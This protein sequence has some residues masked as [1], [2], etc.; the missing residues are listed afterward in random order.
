MNTKTLLFALVSIIYQQIAFAENSSITSY[1][2]P[3]KNDTIVKMRLADI[4]DPDKV[5]KKIITSGIPSTGPQYEMMV[6]M[7]SSQCVKAKE[8]KINDSVSY[9]IKGKP[10]HEVFDN[11][12]SSEVSLFEIM[13][14][15][16][17]SPES[18]DVA[19]KMTTKQSNVNKSNND[20]ILINGA[21]NSAVAYMRKNNIF[22]QAD[23]MLTKGNTVGEL[24]GFMQKYSTWLKEK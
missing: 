1:K 6:N 4:C 19:W 11:K 8:N 17:N 10:V 13:L 5:K 2:Y 16:Y 15:E 9:I 23:L 22:I 3:F 12:I 14:R 7:M 21:Y 18:L 20:Y 24:N